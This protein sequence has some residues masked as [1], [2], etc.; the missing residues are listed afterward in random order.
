MKRILTISI[1]IGVILML[2]GCAIAAEKAKP[3]VKAP[4]TLSAETK[5]M[6]MELQREINTKQKILSIA[7]G[8]YDQAVVTMQAMKHEAERVKMEI[9]QLQN[10]AKLLITPP[11]VEKGK[12]K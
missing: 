5:V 4:V 11:K 3:E 9:T 6:I 7:N 1:I 10:R 12:K 8:T 2:S